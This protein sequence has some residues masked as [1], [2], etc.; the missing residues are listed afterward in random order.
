MFELNPV[1]E[2]VV[3]AAGPASNIMLLLLY[4]GGIQMDIIGHSVPDPNLST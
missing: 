4:F 2:I 1:H 3:A